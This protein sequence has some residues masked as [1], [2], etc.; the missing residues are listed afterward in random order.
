MKI[1]LFVGY[2]ADMYCL[3]EVDVR[4]YD[5]FLEP[6]LTMKG[7]RGITKRKGGV[8]NEGS[9]IFYRPEKLESVS[10]LPIVPSQ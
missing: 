6:Y 1:A 2:H 9:A 8:V 10:S 5:R 7:W 3:Q 4:M